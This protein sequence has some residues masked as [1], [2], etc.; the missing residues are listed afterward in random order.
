MPFP[1][2]G[3][4]RQL[5]ISGL[6]CNLIEITCAKPFVPTRVVI[7]D[8]LRIEVRPLLIRWR[9]GSYLLPKSIMSFYQTARNVRLDTDN[10]TLKAEC[11]GSDGKYHPTSIDLSMY[12]GN[13][14][15][16]FL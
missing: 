7:L 16:S 6:W 13:H 12:L 10:Q 14:G 3:L 1:V 5:K 11:K 4:L 9:V 2:R 15:G 8:N